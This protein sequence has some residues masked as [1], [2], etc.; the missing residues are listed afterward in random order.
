MKVNLFKLDLY[1]PMV[2][3]KYK[4][5]ADV[6]KKEGF[7]PMQLILAIAKVESN[8][9]PFAIKYEPHY[10]YLYNPDWFAHK[11]G[12]TL[13]T[14]EALQKMSYGVYQIMGAV[15]REYGYEGYL[16]TLATSDLLFMQTQLAI[17][18]LVRLYKYFGN[19]PDTIEGYNKGFIRVDEKL[20]FKKVLKAYKDLTSEK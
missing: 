1:I 6:I 11:N 18:H 8:F 3:V 4:E 5:F 14:E 7:E 19:I 15:A 20:Y 2:L 9:N 10:K 16:Q 17:K 13:E 12:I